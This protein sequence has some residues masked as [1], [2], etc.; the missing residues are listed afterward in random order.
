MQLVNLILKKDIIL[1]TISYDILKSMM[2]MH[3]TYITHK[4]N[5]PTLIIL[6][7]TY[8]INMYLQAIY[9]FKNE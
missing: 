8:Y 5:Y 9:L 7:I 2:V 1:K 4:L 3:I 6:L